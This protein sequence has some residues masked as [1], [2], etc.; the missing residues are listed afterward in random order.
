MIADNATYRTAIMSVGACT[1]DCHNRKSTCAAIDLCATTSTCVQTCDCARLERDFILFGHD[2]TLPMEPEEE[3]PPQQCVEV[4]HKLLNDTRM[5]YSFV[6][7]AVR[8][9][10]RIVKLHFLSARGTCCLKL[11]R[12][13]QRL[14]LAVRDRQCMRDLFCRDCVRLSPR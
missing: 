2:N 3:A 12:C 9:R 4:V 5:T 11:T 8:L 10:L 7:D 13:L 6:L 1:R 14:L